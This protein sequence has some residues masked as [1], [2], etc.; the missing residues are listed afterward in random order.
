M[1]KQKGKCT[2]CGRKCSSDTAKTCSMSC[3]AKLSHRTMKRLKT[4]NKGIGKCEICGSRCSSIKAKTCCGSCAAKL[5]WK[6]MVENG[7][8]AY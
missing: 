6:T 8:Y 5:A 3:A 2:I 1:K 7:T 4:K